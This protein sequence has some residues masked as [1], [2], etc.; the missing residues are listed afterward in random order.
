MV[1]IAFQ[2][3]GGIHGI[4]PC[5][6]TGDSS[7]LGFAEHQRVNDLTLKTGAGRVPGSAGTGAPSTC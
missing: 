6:T 7:T 4:V 2:S 5:G 3:A 1:L